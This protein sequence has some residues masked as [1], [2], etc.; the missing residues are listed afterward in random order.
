M[1]AVKSMLVLYGSQTG[2]AEDAAQRVGREAERRGFQPRVL[3]AD[4]YMNTIESLPQEEIV[5]F[6]ISTTGQ[7]EFPS[8]SSHFWKF[9]RRKSLG[10]ESLQ[11]VKVAVFGLG[12]SGYLKFNYSAKLMFRRLETLG[13][14]PV[15]ELGLGDDQHK[16]GY[17]AALDPWLNTLWNALGVDQRVN[18]IMA[19]GPTLIAPKYGVRTKADC[20][21]TRDNNSLHTYR[22]SIAAAS[23]LQ[24]LEMSKWGVH[25]TEEEYLITSVLG[26]GRLTS[27]SHFQDVRLLQIGLKDLDL[28]F[29]PG[30]AISIWPKQDER[31]VEEMLQRCSLAYDDQVEIRLAN[32]NEAALFRAGSIMSGVLDVSS[33]PPRRT[34][35]QALAQ[36][37]PSGMHKDRLLHL[38]SPEGREDLNEYVSEEGRNV[39]DVLQDFPSVPITIDWL[40]TVAPRLKPRMYSAASSLTHT[41][42]KVELLIALVEW[43]TPGRR[44]RR[45]LCSKFIRDCASGDHIAIRVEK[46]AIRLPPNDVPLIM[47]G[48]GTG[49]APFRS[50]L[51]ERQHL[52][53]NNK[54]H[55]APSTLFYGCRNRSKD[56]L[57]IPEWESMLAS[58]TLGHL[59][60]A[61]SRDT[62]SKVYVTHDMKAHAATVWDL[63][64]S[65]ASIF[66]AGRADRMPGDVERT[67]L[68]IFSTQ[69]GMDLTQAKKLLKRM[70]STS[71][72]QVECWS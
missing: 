2:N 67:L 11:H 44:I 5:I 19:N 16:F 46:G 4:Y 72:Y 61:C 65:G 62:E 63:V 25:F 50:F 69:G 24:E 37:Y 29:S 32:Q 68:D 38:S 10:P 15:V 64:S 3:P 42:D 14:V 70:E 49:V 47:I 41:P 9:L 39:L 57:F 40:L 36:L 26:N 48:P 59:F 13:A 21:P 12:D 7:G 54:V 52:N 22:D 31:A 20:A 66:V 6:V 56:C 18:T 8:N 35:F 33:A 43:K 30:D 45:G 53:K 71:R 55:C 1:H 17:D 27:P 58:G 28:M 60:I 51:Q 23:R 34:F